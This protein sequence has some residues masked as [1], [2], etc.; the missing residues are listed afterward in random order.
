VTVRG[1]AVGKALP[2]VSPAPSPVVPAWIEQISP[3]GEVKPLA[4]IRVIFAHPL[5]PLQA[6]EDPS[7]QDKLAQFTVDPPIP[8][9]F[10]FLTPRMVGF[11]QDQALPLSSRFRITVHAGL[12]DLSG[13]TLDRDVA[14]SFTT[15]PLAITD[16]PSLSS[17]DDEGDDQSGQP[18]VVGLTPTIRFRSNVELDPQSL[19]DHVS[20]VNTKT[21]ASVPI[22]VA[23][24]TS[25]TPGPNDED[26]PQ[27]T[28][29]A[30]SRDWPY[31]V[32]PKQPLDKDTIYNVVVS[33]GLMPARGNLPST[34]TF[35]GQIKTYGQLAFQGLARETQ[36]VDRFLGGT[37]QLQF[38]NPL[39]AD[40]VQKNLSIHPVPQSTAG[41]WQVSDGDTSV[42]VNTAWLVPRTT[43]TIT[44]GP[45]VADSFGQTL[46]TEKQATLSTGDLTANFWMPDGVNIFPADDNLQLN[47]SAVNLPKGEYF[48]IF[49]AMQP[50]DVVAFDNPYPDTSGATLLPDSSQ[51]PA[52]RVSAARNQVMNAAVPLRQ[53]LGG[54]FGMLAYG[55]EATTQQD[56]PEVKFYGFI[57]LTNLGVFAQWF[58]TQGLVRVAHLSDGSNVAGAQIAIYS[59]PD[60]PCATGT[61][62]ANGS[63]LISADATQRCVAQGLGSYGGPTLVAIAREGDDWAYA[64]TDPYSGAYGYGID[65][66]WDRGDPQ[67]RGTIFSDRSLYQPGEKAEFTGAA[68]YVQRGVLH[69]DRNAPYRLTL[70]APDGG[71]TDLGT[72]TTD[73]YGMFSLALPLGQNQPLGYY[74]VSAKGPSGATVTGDFRVAEFKPP[75]FKVDLSLEK[76]VAYAGDTVF[77]KAVSTYLFGSPVT[78]GQASYYVTRQ[79]TTFTPKGLDD[80]TFGRQWFWPE[81]PPSISSDV[82]QAKT[83]LGDNGQF[84]QQINVDASVP[85]PLIYQVD[86]QVVDV[87]N[88]S[89]ADSK[90]FTVLPGDELIGLQSDW[91]GTAGKPLSVTF[92]V[93]DANGA[94]QRGRDVTFAL[95]QMNYGNAAQ[96][97]EGGESDVNSVQYKTVATVRAT[98]GDTPQTVTLTPTAPGPYRIRANFADAKDDTTAT[99]TQVWVTG[100]GE[101]DW[102]AYDQNVLQVK[103]DKKTYRV[104]DT[105]TALI[106]SPYPSGQLYF[107]IVRD[108]ILTSSVQR[109]SGS[110]P[111]VHF[112]ITPDMLPN[113]AVEAVL[114][115][116][117][118]PLATL[119][120]GSIDSLARTGFAPFAIDLADKYLKVT[121]TPAHASLEPG[122]QQ[123]VDLAVRDAHGRPQRGELAV[124]A[125]NETVLQLTGYR[126]PDLVQTVYAPQFISTI[127]ADNRPNVILAQIA[128]P[129]QKGW[130]YG[131][132]FLAGAA[133]TR[134]R[135]NFQ[136]LAYYN[137]AVHTDAN[138]LAHVTFTLPDDLTTWRVMAVAVSSGSDSSTDFRFGNADTTF[139]TSKPLVSNP[140]LP[141]FVRP[142]DTI[143]G[144]VSVTNVSA[145]SGTLDILGSLSGPLVFKP[146]NAESATTSFSGAAPSATSAYRFTMFATGVG[147]AQV[148]FRSGIGPA[149]DAFQV[150][151]TVS[152][153]LSVMES[154]VESGVTKTSATVPVKVDANV[155]NDTGGLEVDLASTLIPE[156]TAPAKSALRADDLPLLEP[157]ASRLWMSADLKMLAKRYGGSL[158]SFD[159]DTTGAQAL[160]Q[161]AKLQRGDGGFAWCPCFSESSVFV[162]PYVAR[163]LAVAS[164]AGLN[165]SPAMLAH[166]KTYL[167][168]K[169]A[170]P[171]VCSGIPNCLAR[172]RLDILIALGDLGEPR[173]DFLSDIYDARDTFDLLGQV[174]LARYLLGLPGWHSQGAAMADKLQEIVYVTGRYATINYPEEWGWLSSPA[175]MRAEALRLYIARQTDPAFL[176]KLASGLLALRRNGTWQDS[177]DTAAALSALVAYGALEQT[178][179]NFTAMSTYAGKT[180]QSVRFNGYKV[181][182]DRSVVPIAQL[183]RGSND[184]VLAKSGTGTLHYLVS[185]AYRLQGVQP[186]QLAGLRITREVRPANKDTVLARMGLNA[187]ND[188]LTLSAGEIL[189]VG[190]EIIT[191]HPVDHAV[192]TD[193]LPA[194]LEAVDTS[195]K[196]STPYFEAAG[197]SW[198]IDYQTIYK[199]RIVAY[200][201]RL[202]AGVYTLHYLVRSVT[203]GTYLWPGADVHLQFAPE[204][205]GRTS[206]STLIVS[207]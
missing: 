160:A 169:L 111:E 58:P 183:P 173:T 190:L 85:Y 104:G 69:Q 2:A 126:P 63:F 3:K 52:V 201:T 155:A 59:S 107:A 64:R 172:V 150:P 177:Y 148:K 88:L 16:L 60:A 184:L 42:S 79:Q 6:I 43:Y 187:P 62:D 151:L 163:S 20:L 167:E 102:G 144:G 182:T 168:H 141:Q 65:T 197:D 74:T 145:G 22:S 174:Q 203:P 179:P 195:F 106:Q 112:R 56:P 49:K 115:R 206:T 10:R 127:F 192:I 73:A 48:A 28:F 72:Q 158:G 53:K 157:A 98:S 189:D 90:T 108:R 38:N 154:V 5:I 32:T 202:E 133:S 54:K 66:Q 17:Q 26:Q 67:S 132:G 117:G 152:E 55:A 103:L 45:G 136:P 105:A 139:V 44:I 46:G 121:L 96:I 180:L 198:E 1:G 161:L 18:H 165:V 21:K 86:A 76:S 82:L 116:R 156:I 8:G 196:T 33:A 91:V 24:D 194:G 129:L 171:S 92:V 153:P 176:D 78:A 95:A 113:A 27:N 35:T 47:I 101:V 185:Y 137:G 31:L 4:Q 170:D 97:V 83:P 7:Q 34:Q 61:T 125:V 207:E 122:A 70:Y 149:A 123:T 146:S 30:S 13:N 205:F 162:T 81:Q 191:D 80:Y 124:M 147:T 99:D 159:P 23:P 175:V 188:P 186:G 57:G 68:Y 25:N 71:K 50:R 93:S 119:P 181:T 128:S 200:A 94:L 142:G 14:W 77:A 143:S 199:D 114:V 109:V 36:V 130:G 166:V 204:E 118:K 39:V 37:P 29:D 11:Q 100:P 12:G 15:A 19:A 75:N 84:E 140:L 134:V 40:S 138:G 120:P 51:W 110:A 41:L 9:R 135:T 193:E 87:S 89:V 164:A 178:P 131:G